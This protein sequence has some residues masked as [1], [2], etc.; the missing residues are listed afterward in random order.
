MTGSA[1]GDAVQKPEH[2]DPLAWSLGVRFWIVR[3]GSVSV[4]RSLGL[5]RVTKTVF[6][7]G[8]RSRGFVR[9]VGRRTPQVFFKQ[10]INIEFSSWTHNPLVPGSS[11]GGQHIFHCLMALGQRDCPLPRIP[12]SEAPLMEFMALC[13]WDQ[14]NGGSLGAWHS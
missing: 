9:W 4:D 12:W 11:P 6:G 13:L 1:S 10:L 14:G 3:S 7:I 8:V 5:L 2:S